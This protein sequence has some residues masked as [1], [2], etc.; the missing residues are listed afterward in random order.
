MNKIQIYFRK[1]RADKKCF[2]RVVKHCFEFIVNR[3]VDSAQRGFY[4]AAYSEH[5]KHCF[6]V[7]CRN[8]VNT[9]NAV[10]I[11]FYSAVKSTTV[12]YICKKCRSVFKQSLGIICIYGKNFINLFCFKRCKFSAFHKMVYVISVRRF[13]RNSASACVHLLNK[14]HI[15][16]AS[17]F[18]SDSGA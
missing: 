8:D 12:C 17:H 18:V 11:I 15:G 7:S 2:H 13:A 9:L 14:P 5:N 3:A 10:Q 1:Q 16:K 6:A 4:F